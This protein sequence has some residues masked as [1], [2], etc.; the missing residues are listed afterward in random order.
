[1]LLLIIRIVIFVAIIAILI[2][3]AFYGKNYA[4]KND[5]SVP[6][7]FIIGL[8]TGPIGLTLVYIFTKLPEK[9]AGIFISILVFI[10]V[11]ILF[12][13]TEIF[14]GLEWNAIDFRF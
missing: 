1:M 14:K 11:T 4:I 7:L 8:L 10:I 3:S 13:N 6:F 9:L 5:K 12:T 2:A